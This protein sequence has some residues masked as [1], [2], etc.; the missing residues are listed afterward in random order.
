MADSGR[1]AIMGV[2]TTLDVED[3]KVVVRLTGRH[4]VM[5]L[6]RQVSVPLDDI[7][8]VDAIDDGFDVDL[9]WR[10]GGTGIPRRLAFGRFRKRGVRTFAAVYCGEPAVV[11]ETAGGDWN[12]LVIS[13]D[14]AGG[15]AA[16]VREA[17]GLRAA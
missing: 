13:V 7:R 10:V 4:A 14:D 5:A 6:A 9:G 12:R 1:L 15:T 16:Q 11:V 8:K 3:G 2:M 17:A